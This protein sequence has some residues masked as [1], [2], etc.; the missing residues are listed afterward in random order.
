MPKEKATT[1]KAAK[2]AKAD[3]GGKKKKDPN[4]PKRGLSAY[5]FFANDQ[6]DKVRE[7]NPGIKFGEVGKKLGEQWKSLNDKQKAPYEAKAAA[8][9]KRYEEE[10]AAYTAS[11]VEDEEEE[12]E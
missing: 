5:M 12:E 4:M 9:K 7:D 11:P 1:R 10:K 2:G 6:R 8:D 3:G